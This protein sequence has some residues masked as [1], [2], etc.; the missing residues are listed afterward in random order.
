ME[1]WVTY[2][3]KT[4]LMINIFPQYYNVTLTRISSPTILV[5]LKIQS[6]PVQ[7]GIE[8]IRSGYSLAYLINGLV[9]L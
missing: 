7:K 1:L 6:G 8:P 3:Q 2:S 5:L 9:Q 4:F